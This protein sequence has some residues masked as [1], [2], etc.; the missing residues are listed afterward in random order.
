MKG[1]NL[2]YWKQH[3]FPVIKTWNPSPI[4][5]GIDEVVVSY[6]SAFLGGE[7]LN[8]FGWEMIGLTSGKYSFIDVDGD[9]DFW[10]LARNLHKKI[11]TSLKGG[12]KFVAS[13][14]SEALLKMLVRLDSMRLCASAVNYN[15]V[16]S[17][18]SSYGN[19]KVFAVHGFVSAHAFG[20]E[21]AS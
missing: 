19:M 7:I 6:A 16:G 1:D 9:G 14:M 2:S 20:P 17:V 10:S 15:G 11:Y 3:E 12:D 8:A 21:M 4:S 5:A 13:A 18:Q